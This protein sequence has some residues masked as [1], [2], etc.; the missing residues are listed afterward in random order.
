MNLSLIYCFSVFVC[1]TLVLY[2]ARANA[3]FDVLS[4]RATKLRCREEPFCYSYAEVSCIE[5]AHV[6]YDVDEPINR[7]HV[8][9]IH[10][11]TC[12]QQ[13][14]SRDLF[15]VEL[16]TITNCCYATQEEVDEA[17]R[18]MKLE[19]VP[20]SFEGKLVILA[21]IVITIL[22]ITCIGW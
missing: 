13:Q 6:T 2:V 15:Y 4:V 19:V 5:S 22:A 8:V 3:Q 10:H 20:I 18:R 7:Q 17:V 12:A 14:P 1:S 21:G 16:I 9:I 11:E